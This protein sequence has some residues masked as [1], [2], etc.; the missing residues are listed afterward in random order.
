MIS[1]QTKKWGIPGSKFV[2]KPKIKNPKEKSFFGPPSFV[3]NLE[4][5]SILTS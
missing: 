1:N 3:K 4:Q 5:H 2:I